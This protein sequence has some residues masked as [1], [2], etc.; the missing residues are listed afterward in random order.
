[1]VLDS[2]ATNGFAESA[3]DVPDS[4]AEGNRFS[5]EGEGP[6]F[7]SPDPQAGRAASMIIGALLSIQAS[8]PSLPEAR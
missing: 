1:M 4:L 2:G 5:S 6:R 7:R 3:V 8:L